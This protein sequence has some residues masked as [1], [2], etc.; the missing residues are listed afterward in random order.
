MARRAATSG[1]KGGKHLKRVAVGL[2]GVPRLLHAPVGADKEGRADNTLA[3]SWPF[4]PRPVRPMRLAVGIAQQ[5]H[6]KAVLLA[7][8]L[9]RGG[10]V[11]RDAEHGHAEHLELRAVV[12]ELAGLGRAARRLARWVAVDD[13]PLPLEVLCGD[14]FAFFVVQRQRPGL[15]A[16]LELHAADGTPPQRP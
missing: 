4:A 13:I 2:H 6:A 7:E 16:G 8:R 15:V 11:L 14:D 9:M 5:A 12:G 1:A 10:V 3:A